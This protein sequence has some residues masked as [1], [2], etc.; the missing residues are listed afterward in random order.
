MVGRNRKYSLA[1]GKAQ[2]T[3]ARHQKTQRRQKNIKGQSEGIRQ[4]V[5]ETPSVESIADFPIGDEDP[6]TPGH[7]Y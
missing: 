2:V 4:K 7:D 6:T 1:L 5:V 3:D